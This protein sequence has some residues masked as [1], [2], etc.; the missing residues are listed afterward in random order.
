[1]KGYLLDTSICVFLLRG[2]RSV[3]DRLNEID[4]TSAIS[5]M[6]WWLN[7]CSVPTTAN[8]LRKISDR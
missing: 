4:E 5:P 6:L 7:F 2:K 3:E 8:G 1:M